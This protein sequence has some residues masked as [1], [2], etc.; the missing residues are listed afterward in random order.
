MHSPSR[1]SICFSGKQFSRTVISVTNPNITKSS[2]IG[3]WQ[4]LKSNYIW[5]DDYINDLII[6][7]EL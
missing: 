5:I 4:S 6:I 1:V 2:T 3:K 7:Y